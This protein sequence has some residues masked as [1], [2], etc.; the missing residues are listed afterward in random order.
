MRKLLTL[1]FLLMAGVAVAQVPPFIRHDYTT[2]TLAQ[3]DARAVVAN[4]DRPTNTFSGTTFWF[5]TNQTIV[6]SS[7]IYITA[8]GNLPT[9]TERVGQLTI[10]ASGGAVTVTNLGALRCSDGVVSRVV[11][12]GGRLVIGAH[13]QIPLFTNAA[14]VQF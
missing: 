14:V 6:C 1:C 9:T 12:D 10:I 3:A 7:N 2:G 11:A 13:V 5:G 4:M 8:L